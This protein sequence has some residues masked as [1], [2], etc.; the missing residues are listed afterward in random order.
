MRAGVKGEPSIPII[1]E[2]SSVSDMIKDKGQT[3]TTTH[4][5]T[6]ADRRSNGHN[7]SRY[8]EPLET[9]LKKELQSVY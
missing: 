2:V 4:S 8:D 9:H 1:N 3:W 6:T 7:Y 5:R